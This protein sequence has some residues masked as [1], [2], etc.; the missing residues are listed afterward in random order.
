MV[1]KRQTHHSDPG[2]RTSDEEE[3]DARPDGSIL[4]LEH[5]VSGRIAVSP[6]NDLGPCGMMV[7][8]TVPVS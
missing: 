7:D 5:H 2:E 1:R 3:G 6:L 4:I 8:R